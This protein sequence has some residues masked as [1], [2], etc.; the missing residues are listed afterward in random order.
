MKLTGLFLLKYNGPEAEPFIIGE[1]TDLSS[2]GYFQ[3]GP[4]K[5]GLHFASRTVCRRTVP[6]QRQS[7]QHE[8]YL[9]H[10]YNKGGL[11][12]LAVADKEYPS[13]AAFCILNKCLDDFTGQ[14]PAAA[15]KLMQIQK[16]L[17]ETK[18]PSRDTSLK[19]FTAAA[20]RH[21]LTCL[22]MLSYELWNYFHSFHR[23]QQ[24]QEQT[25]LQVILHKTI[26]SVL[27]R[28]EKLEQLVDKSSDLSMASQMFYKQVRTSLQNRYLTMLLPAD[29]VSH[30]GVGYHSNQ[31]LRNAGKENKLV[32]QNDVA[33]PRS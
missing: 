11:A 6:G 12:A 19:L 8:E 16:D 22:I 26:E 4:V 7:V 1:A 32:L 9:I 20:Q 5:Q 25:L 3:R 15:D 33:S 18:V 23:P 14:D 29:V 13:R 31:C 24:H 2:F 28:G 17:D 10:V 27:E 30:R 21:F